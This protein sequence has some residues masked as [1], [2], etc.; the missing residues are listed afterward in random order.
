MG[1]NHWFTGN[2]CNFQYTLSDKGDWVRPW[3]NNGPQ[4]NNESVSENNEQAKWWC[5][6]TDFDIETCGCDYWGIDYDF[7]YLKKYKKWPDVKFTGKST[8][9]KYTTDRGDCVNYS[10]P[11]R[12]PNYDNELTTPEGLTPV[13]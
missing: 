4:R 5:R 6:Y 1:L 3:W 10:C 11:S 13:S 7:R 12:Y 9:P 2:V 8:W